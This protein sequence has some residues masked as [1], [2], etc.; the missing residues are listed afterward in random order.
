MT[1]FDTKDNELEETVVQI[2]RITKVVKGGRRLRFAAIVVVGDKSGH[3]GFGT[4]KAQ[5]VPEAIRKAAEAAR[6]NMITVP[7][8]G[9]TIPHTVKGHY[10]SGHIL[11]KPAREGSGI[12]AGGAVRSVLELAGVGDITSKSQ[13]S[14]TPINVIRATF[15][16]LQQLRTAQQTAEL[17]GISIDSL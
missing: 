8:S 12:S 2:N 14:N 16:G 13:G 10:G 5:E 11:L 15:D 4:G 6:K 1:D 3:V 9:T 7:K 17:R